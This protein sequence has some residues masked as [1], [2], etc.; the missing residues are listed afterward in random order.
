MSGDD[1]LQERQRRA[2]LNQSRFRELNEAI[3]DRR[4]SSA[5][6]EYACECA[7]LTCEVTV[8]LAVD[9]YEEVRRVPTHFFVAHGHVFPPAENV[10]RETQRYQVV[11][12]VGVAGKVGSVAPT[13][14][15][16]SHAAS[17]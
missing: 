8:A 13:R 15:P 4:D 5:F 3:E 12:K 9:E 6:T 2:A 7:Q 10:V 16:P 17:G 11:E 14:A 1:E